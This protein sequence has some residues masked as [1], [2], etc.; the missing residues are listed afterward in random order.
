MF[1]PFFT[2]NYRRYSEH[3]SHARIAF[4]WKSALC[5]YCRYLRRVVFSSSFLP[6]KGLLAGIHHCHYY[7]MD[8]A[9]IVLYI[10]EKE[11]EGEKLCGSETGSQR[12]LGEK[13]RINS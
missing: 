11:K 4:R 3:L 7:K 9:L 6:L 10:E 8:V 2:N 1:E 13:T 5:F 12:E